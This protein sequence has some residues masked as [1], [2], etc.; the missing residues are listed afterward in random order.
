MSM[1]AANHYPLSP[2]AFAFPD[3]AKQEFGNLVGDIGVQ[4]LLEPITVWRGEIIDG[5]HRYLACLE[6]G[7]KPGYQFLDDD[8]NPILYLV[9]VQSR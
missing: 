3:Y 2:L 6:A 5:R 1:S 8:V 4:G 7:V 9:T